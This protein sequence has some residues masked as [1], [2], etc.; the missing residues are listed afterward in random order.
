MLLDEYYVQGHA[1]MLKADYDVETRSDEHDH[2]N[3]LKLRRHHP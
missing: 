2:G 1:A 3:T